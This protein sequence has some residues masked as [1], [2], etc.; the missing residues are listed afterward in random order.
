MALNDGSTVDPSADQ[1]RKAAAA[2][3]ASMNGGAPAPAHPAAGAMGTA[4]IATPGVTPTSYSAPVPTTTA[5]AP[6]AIPAPAPSVAPTIGGASTTNG[7]TPYD[8]VAPGGTIANTIGQLPG[9]DKLTKAIAPVQG[10][11]GALTPDFLTPKLAN[12]QPLVGAANTAF[13][14]SAGLANERANYQPLAAPGAVGTQLQTGN[15]DPTRAAQLDLASRLQATAAGTAGP[16]AADL[17]MKQAMDQSA[18]QQFGLASALQG[19]SAGGALRQASEG[20]AN[21]LGQEAAAG[22]IQ[23][24][25]EVQAA[26]SQLGSTLGTVAGQD[27]GIAGQNATMN[28]QTQLANL[29]AKLNTMG[30][31]EATKNAILQAQISSQ[32][33]GVTAAGD[34]VKANTA[35][36]DAQNKANGGVLGTVSG[37]LGML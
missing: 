35:N 25:Q 21:I 26:N 7:Q 23:R 10:L 30:L 36:A 3:A 2:T 9:G 19:R 1:A 29:S 18:A 17:Q 24:A 11:V 4:P 31:D 8:P 14:T 32:G 22:G 20:S 6:A 27:I 13:G 28:Q 33:Q 16:S 5:P 12:T 15:Y 34:L 37:V